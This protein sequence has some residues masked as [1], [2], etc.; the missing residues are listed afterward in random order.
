MP[1]ASSRKATSSLLGNARRDDLHASTELGPH[2]VIRAQPPLASETSTIRSKRALRE[3]GKLSSESHRSLQSHGR[4]DELVDK[5][6][7]ESLLP[8]HRPPGENQVHRAPM[9]D[10]PRQPDR[11]KVDQRYAET[12]VEYAER[13][14]RSCHT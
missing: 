11:A 13:G 4:F 1:A 9:A 3:G 5:P 8:E 7:I 14:V 10:E 6:D 12:P 2:G